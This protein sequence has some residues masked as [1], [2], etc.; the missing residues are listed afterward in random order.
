[1]LGGGGGGGRGRYNFMVNFTHFLFADIFGLS[2]LLL[3]LS[4]FFKTMKQTLL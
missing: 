3:S 4:H 2:K 1:M